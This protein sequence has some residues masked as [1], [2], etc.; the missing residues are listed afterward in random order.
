[1][2]LP[3]IPS[4]EQAAT[5]AA[6]VLSVMSM[7]FWVQEK[8]V[9]VSASIGIVVYPE[10]GTSTDTLLKHAGTA[11]SHVKGEG[12]NG[13]QFYSEEIN[14]RS[15][16]R[17]NLENRLHKAHDNEELFLAYQPKVE[18]STGA[19]VGMEALARWKH[20]QLGLVSPARF[21]PIAEDT[22]LIAGIGRWA[23]EEAC[24]QTKAWNNTG[25]GPLRIAVNV[26]ARQFRQTDFVSVVSDT[27]LTTG[28]DP[29]LLTIELTESVVMVNA[30]KSIDTLRRLKEMGISLSIDDFGT[31]Y[32]SLSYLKRFPLDE[33]KVDRS[34]LME[35]DQN[36]DDAAI[37][38]AIVAMAHS[39][40]LKVVAEGV[41]TPEQL[42]FLRNIECDLLQG[43]FFSKPVG[44]QEFPQ[45]AREKLVWN[46]P[47]A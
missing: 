39:L 38:T 19:V 9:F 28:L 21:I 47:P 23:L 4:A 14:V 26:S 6:R 5:V 18:L 32:S 3:E 1:V 16:E 22:G 45:V 30:Q 11:T 33:L 10:D 15:A 40:G 31:G 20:P 7:P 34:F 41:E 17:L 35:V 36:S 37:V 8:E 42:T 44:A 13:Y 25:L 2:L 46:S 12:G 29:S 43:Y 24:L 27:L